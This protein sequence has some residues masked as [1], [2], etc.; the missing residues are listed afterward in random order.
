L[1]ICKW[2]DLFN[3]CEL[4]QNELKQKMLVVLF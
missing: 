2:P 4:K 3:F 1:L